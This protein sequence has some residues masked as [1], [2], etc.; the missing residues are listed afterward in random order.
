MKNVRR[1]FVTGKPLYSD[2]ETPPTFE[3]TALPLV[4]YLFREN[5]LIRCIAGAA[6]CATE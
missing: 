2:G 1:G 4:K 5:A 3:I 6:R